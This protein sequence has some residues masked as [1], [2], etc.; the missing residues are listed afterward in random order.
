MMDA[1]RPARQHEHDPAPRD[2]AVA[3]RLDS[4]DCAAEVLAIVAYLTSADGPLQDS[5]AAARGVSPWHPRLL[6][7]A[8]ERLNVVDAYMRGQV[9]FLVAGKDHGYYTPESE[10]ELAGAV[11]DTCRATTSVVDAL[12]AGR[13]PTRREFETMSAAALV[14]D[15]ALD[16]ARRAEADADTR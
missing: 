7:K 9:A 4:S 3:R 2:D 12:I 5:T 14:V 13:L 1:G 11:L 6:L 15:P 16:A 8:S 10:L